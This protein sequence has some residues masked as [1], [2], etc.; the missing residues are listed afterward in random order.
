[1]VDVV[2]AATSRL[3]QD[4]CVLLVAHSK[5]G[6]FVPLL[7]TTPST[8][9]R[10]CLFADAALPAQ[11][12]QTPVAPTELLDFLR[13]KVSNGG[14]RRGPSGGAGRTSRHRSPRARKRARR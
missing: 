8:G 5:A 7:V 14:F 3:D 6:L 13:G 11:A 9:C 2:N 10:C 4:Q 1:M 12:R